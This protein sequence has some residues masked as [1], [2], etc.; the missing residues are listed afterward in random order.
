MSWSKGLSVSASSDSSFTSN[1]DL[2]DA[3]LQFVEAVNMKGVDMSTSSVIG[4]VAGFFQGRK[5]ISLDVADSFEL[6]LRH[7]FG[8]CCCLWLMK[9]LDL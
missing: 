4:E 2:L 3:V 5:D 6:G 9:L 8:L 7:L 1:S